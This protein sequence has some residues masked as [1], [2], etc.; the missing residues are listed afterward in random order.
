MYKW[1]HKLALLLYIGST[2]A[3]AFYLSYSGFSYYLTPLE[4][5]FFH[6]QHT[7]LK[8]SGPWGHGFGIIGSLF[9][10]LGVG[11]Y[12]ARK[13]LKV[14]SRL[15]KL[16]HW[17]EFH[18]FLCTVGPL[19]VLFH[20]AFKFGGIVS[21][22]FWSMVAVFLSGIIG[23]FIYQQLPRTAEGDMLSLKELEMLNLKLSNALLTKGSQT[24]W[25]IEKLENTL[26]LSTYQNTPIPQL[27]LFLLKDYFN[28]K[29]FL[30]NTK[31][32][33]LQGY[34]THQEALTVFYMVKEK[35]ELTRKTGLLKTME[36][37]FNY[38]HIIHLPFAI[39]MVVI[40]VIHIAVTLLFG[41]RWI[42]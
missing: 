28:K 16:K 10:V 26:S 40:M 39:I 32:A 21:I 12:M 18:I 2:V 13:R 33:L 41:Y 19:L 1:L 25:L 14:F 8:P 29:H 17:L 35:T 37:A 27:P 7:Q 11:L 6:A 34:H 15:G 20:T 30:K 3:I 22:S 4:E 5:R 23:R 31:K 24:P 38:W 36:R 9:M 42:F